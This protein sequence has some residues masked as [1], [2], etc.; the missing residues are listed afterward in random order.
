MR[1]MIVLVL[2]AA[3]LALPTG[4]ITASPATAKV[5]ARASVMECGGLG[6]VPLQRQMQFGPSNWI[7]QMGT[8]SDG[9]VGFKVF[10]PTGRWDQYRIR[11]VYNDG[12]VDV[13]QEYY[14][15][16]CFSR[17]TLNGIRRVNFEARNG[18]DWHVSQWWLF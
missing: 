13:L 15:S 11:V 1:K 12:R 6:T 9:A 3:M 18:G 7:A 2:M 17:W 10:H 4:L 5:A 14:T 8:R 16:F